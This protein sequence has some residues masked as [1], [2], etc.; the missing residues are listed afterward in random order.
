M[1]QLSQTAQLRQQ[2]TVTGDTSFYKVWLAVGV[3]VVVEVM[4]ETQFWVGTEPHF[5]LGRVML[6]VE[7]GLVVKVVLMRELHLL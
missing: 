1:V 3:V 4:L 2:T 5:W 6:I 7:A